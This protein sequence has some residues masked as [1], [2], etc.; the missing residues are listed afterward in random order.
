MLL[1]PSTFMRIITDVKSKFMHFMNIVFFFQKNINYK[2][3]FVVLE[4]MP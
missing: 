1:L 2:S 3:V 4:I